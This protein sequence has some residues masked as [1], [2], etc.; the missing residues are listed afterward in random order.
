MANNASPHSMFEQLF[1]YLPTA[2]A[3]WQLEQRDDPTSLRF[4]TAN[5][6]SIEQVGAELQNGAGQRMIDMYPT[7]P[8]QLLD[9]YAGVIR[10]GQ[11]LNM[12]E[13]TFDAVEGGQVVYEMHLFPLENDHIAVVHS[14]VTDR[15]RAEEAIRQ[16]QAQ[17]EALRA[18]NAILAELSTPLIPIS[19]HVMVMPLIGTV[20][21]RRAQQVMETLLEGTARNQASTIILDITG[22]PVVDT[23]VADALMRAAQALRLLGAEVVLTGIR[24]EVAQTL[25]GLGTD[26]GSITTRS[27]LQSGIAYAIGAAEQGRLSD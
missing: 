2:I 12:G 13:F 11:P 22:V 20:D 4:V 23:Q 26:L 18:Q 15:R 1:T 6:A 27:S 5:P 16:S 8:R 10:S 21:S 24:P 3:I 25:V 19:D 9:T 7:V 14:N 17:E